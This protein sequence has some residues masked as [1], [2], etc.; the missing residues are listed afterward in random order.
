MNDRRESMTKKKQYRFRLSDEAIEY[1]QSYADDH[2][3]PRGDKTE[4]LERIIKEHKELSKQN[5]NLQY[6]T[7]TVTENVTRSVQVALQKSISN[8]INK[9]RLGTNNIDRNSQILIELLQGFMQI[10]NVEHIPTSDL[11]KPEF[12]SHVEKVVQDRITVQ[13]QKKDSKYQ[14]KK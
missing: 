6:I 10:R 4:S 1:I 5:W 9:V 8:E 14:N 3:I 7:K 13:K 12:L 2:E 11:Y